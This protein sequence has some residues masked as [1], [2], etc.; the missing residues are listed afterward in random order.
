MWLGLRD[1][2]CMRCKVPRFAFQRKSISGRGPI[3]RVFL[4]FAVLGFAVV[5]EAPFWL[6][7]ARCPWT[8]RP[9]PESA[10][11]TLLRAANA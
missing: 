11:L 1:K 10:R 5:K 4:R 8:A 2:F 7:L 3:L 6:V 9:L